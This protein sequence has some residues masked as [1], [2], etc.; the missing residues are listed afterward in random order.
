MHQPRAVEALNRHRQFRINIPEVGL[1]GSECHFHHAIGPCA[2]DGFPN[3]FAQIGA[4]IPPF[5]H[6]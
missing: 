3:L 2:L 5:C 6:V 1:I 4:W